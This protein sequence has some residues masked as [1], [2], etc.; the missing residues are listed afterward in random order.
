MIFGV[1]SMVVFNLADTFFV[2]RLGKQQLAGLSVLEMFGL[3]V[4][5][6]LLGSQL[7][8][9]AG[10]FTAIAFSYTVTGLVALWTIRRVLPSR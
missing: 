6:A 5:L 2:G 1:L 9:T 8:G 3:S 10:V 4:P 7:F